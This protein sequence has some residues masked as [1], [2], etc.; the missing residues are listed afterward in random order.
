MR[1]KSSLRGIADQKNINREKIRRRFHTSLNL[2]LSKQIPKHIPARKS[3]IAIVDAKWFKL[4]K[5]QK[6]YTAFVVLLRGVD[7]EYAAIATLDLLPGRETKENWVKIIDRLPKDVQKRIVALISDGFTGL[8]STAEQ[9]GWHFQWCHVHIKR[10]LSELRG[11]RKIPGR[12][13]RR[14]ITKLI[15]LFLETPDE[16]T[17]QNSLE[18]IRKLFTHPNCPRS[19]PYRLSGII[20]RT[21][22]FRTYRAVPKL[23]LPTSTN[24]AENINRQIMDR[25]SSMRGLRSPESLE[26]WI[27]VMYQTIKPVRCRG[28]KNTEKYH[29]KSVS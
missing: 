28:Y 8:M 16:K 26:F 1:S 11:V 27:N 3:L 24:S 14:R 13:I 5:E 19:I 17:A 6:R 10:R 20:K 4:G 18:K 12:E 21:K 15:F 7:E 2:W 22:Y 23:N 9:R 25:L 29:R